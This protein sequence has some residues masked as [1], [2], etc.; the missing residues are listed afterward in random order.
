MAN[1]KKTRDHTV[2]SDQDAPK[3]ERLFDPTTPLR[4]AARNPNMAT[5]RSTNDQDRRAVEQW[6]LDSTNAYVDE[7]ASHLLSY[8]EEVFSVVKNHIDL[9]D[10]VQDAVGDRRVITKEK[11]VRGR[12]LARK[13]MGFFFL[14][15]KAFLLL[16]VF[17]VLVL[18]V[19]YLYENYEGDFFD[20]ID[21][22]YSHY[23]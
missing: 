8:Q 7:I 17:M 23:F 19:F 20:L 2:P 4:F 1:V 6:Q 15:V 22:D 12:S 16:F 3:N 18:V 11:A 10:A 14:I 13:I 21:I 9:I 5:T